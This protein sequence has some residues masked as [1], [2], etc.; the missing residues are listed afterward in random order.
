MLGREV[1]AHSPLGLAALL[2][3]GVPG[4]SWF[5]PTAGWV[6]SA[7]AGLFCASAGNLY[8]LPSVII[9]FPAH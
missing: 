6:C 9:G 7:V 5:L 2:V 4:E 3:A 1:V 8:L